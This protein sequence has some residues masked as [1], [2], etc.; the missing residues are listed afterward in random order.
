[1]VSSLRSGSL[2][3]PPPSSESQDI[4][5]RL[6]RLVGVGERRLYTSTK[7]PGVGKNRSR[8]TL[9]KVCT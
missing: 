2:E 6:S 7:R 4:V 5:P 3:D 9:L 1:M 8:V